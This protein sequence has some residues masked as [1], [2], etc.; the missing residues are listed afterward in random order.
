MKSLLTEPR[1]IARCFALRCCSTA[2]TRRRSCSSGMHVPCP[3]QTTPLSSQSRLAVDT[4]LSASSFP[5]AA[6]PRTRILLSLLPFC[7][8]RAP[9]DDLAPKTAVSSTDNQTPV[10]GPVVRQTS[11]AA[12]DGAL[13]WVRGDSLCKTNLTAAVAELD[14][15]VWS[16]A[17][18]W[19]LPPRSHN[20]P[21]K[22][23]RLAESRAGQAVA[24][25]AV[26]LSKD[27][28]DHRSAKAP[29]ASAPPAIHTRSACG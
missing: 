20:R 3:L 16:A 11:A 14:S 10:C 13:G 21:W 19:I 7:T 25:Y 1:S 17:S 29:D 23:T 6:P 12:T 27:A 4:Q 2:S 28:V 26:Q 22:L 15:L 5:S 24:G 8:A 18:E 9:N